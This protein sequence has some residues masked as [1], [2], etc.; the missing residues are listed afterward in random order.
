MK[1]SS[2]LADEMKKM[3]IKSNMDRKE[4]FKAGIF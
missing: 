2:M 3:R 1:I 4:K